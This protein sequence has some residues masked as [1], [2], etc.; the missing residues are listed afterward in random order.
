MEVAD[1]G[2]HVK[3]RNHSRYIYINTFL[4]GFPFVQ[5][6]HSET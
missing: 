1:L 6:Y 3:K 4:F 5:F 2:E